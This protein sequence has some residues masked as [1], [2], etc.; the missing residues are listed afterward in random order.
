[1][2]VIAADNYRFG[3]S[4]C[5]YDP[6]RWNDGGGGDGPVRESIV[7]EAI[8]T[9]NEVNVLVCDD[10]RLE[11]NKKLTLVGFYAGSSINAA[12]IGP[13]FTVPLAFLILFSGG[14]GKFSMRFEI[15]APSGTK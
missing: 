5:S 3:S 11:M 1:M 7:S 12:N 10:V 15:K 14:E 13:Q 6:T 4:Q 2:V 9:D 8:P